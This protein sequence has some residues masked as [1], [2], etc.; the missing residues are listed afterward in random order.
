MSNLDDDL[1]PLGDVLAEREWADAVTLARADIE[2]AMGRRQDAQ[3]PIAD[4]TSTLFDAGLGYNFVI[5][6]NALGPFG[7]G[8]SLR[9]EALYRHDAHGRS[10]LGIDAGPDQYFQDLVL[11]VGLRIPLGGR[12]GPAIEAPSEPVAV[13]PVEEAAPV[14][15]TPPPA[16]KPCEP[17][18]PGQPISLEGCKEGDTLVLRGVNFEFDKSKLTVNAKALLDPVADALLARPDIKVEVDGHTDSRGSDSYNLKLSDA[19][20]ASVMAYLT[21]RGVDAGRMTSKGFGETMPV[22]DNATDDGR[23]LNRRV[24]LKITES[25]GGGAAEG[26]A[27]GRPSSTGRSTQNS[28][29]RSGS[30]VNPTR[31][32]I[33]SAR[34]G[35]GRFPAS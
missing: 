21:S 31:P 8:M 23:E 22:A 13:V 26:V 34:A 18:V 1:V 11:G 7:P 27:T 9:V 25:A 35:V 3:G 20:A 16:E 12:A 5:S 4:Y 2:R 6:K 32:R 17:P 15:E 29:P 33:S 14:E 28:E 30:V 10:Q 24:E 19:R